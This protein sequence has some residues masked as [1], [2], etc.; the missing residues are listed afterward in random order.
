[1]TRTIGAAIGLLLVVLFF[2]SLGFERA[3]SASSAPA[4]FTLAR[5]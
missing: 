4:T 2:A 1:M 3:R 5:R